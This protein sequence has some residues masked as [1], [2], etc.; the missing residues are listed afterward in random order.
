MVGLKVLYPG[1][2]LRPFP[3]P[4]ERCWPCLQLKGGTGLP[5]GLG[6]APTAPTTHSMSATYIVNRPMGTTQ[7]RNTVRMC[8]SH[9]CVHLSVVSNSLRPHGRQPP[10]ILCPWDSP[11]KNTGVDYQF[12][13]YPGIKPRSP[14]LQADSLP[15]EPPGKPS[16]TLESESVNCS[17]VSDSLQPHRL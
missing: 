2:G 1:P 4:P 16:V 17:V 14:A 5:R 13:P 10:R 8:V 9:V 15:S 3:V 11:G 6:P 12:L 7:P